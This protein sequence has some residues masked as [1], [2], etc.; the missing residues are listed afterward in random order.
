MLERLAR[1]KRS[2]LFKKVVTYG[3]KKFYN[4]GHRSHPEN[5]EPL[6]TLAAAFP[7][8]FGNQFEGCITVNCDPN[9]WKV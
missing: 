4:I 5:P 8:L 3:R 7:E 6:K 2:S 1:D 9:A